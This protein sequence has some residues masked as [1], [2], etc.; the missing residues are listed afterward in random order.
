MDILE[1]IYNEKISL[2]EAYRLCDEMIEEVHRGERD[3]HWWPVLGLSDYEATAFAHGA[4]LE[5]L[6]KLRYEG[7]PT[8]CSR[9]RLPL[10]YTLYGWLFDG[11]DD[12]TLRLKHI[13]CPKGSHDEVP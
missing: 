13:V 12:D 6:V 5:N 3:P 11:S 1:L 7:W 8:I 4:S 2:K 10:D 9:C